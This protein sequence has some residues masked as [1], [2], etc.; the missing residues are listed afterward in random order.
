MP[1]FPAQLGSLVPSAMLECDPPACGTVDKVLNW[2]RSV[3]PAGRSTPPPR[4]AGAAGELLPA[5]KWPL[6][7]AV[8]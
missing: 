1:A 5:L 8:C 4:D 7:A 2:E 3:L 6:F